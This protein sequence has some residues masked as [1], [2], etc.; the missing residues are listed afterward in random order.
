[1]SHSRSAT[2]P[3]VTASGAGVSIPRRF[4]AHSVETIASLTGSTTRGRW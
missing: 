2:A 1:M 3:S 4:T